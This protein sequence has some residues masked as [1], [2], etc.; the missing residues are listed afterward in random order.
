MGHGNRDCAAIEASPS[1]AWLNTEVLSIKRH[2][3]KT[4]TRAWSLHFAVTVSFSSTYSSGLKSGWMILSSLSIRS[5]S[6][7]WVALF[8][9][10]LETGIA[11]I[12]C[13]NV[14]CSWRMWS[15]ELCIP[16]SDF[17]TVL[18]EIHSSLS[19][20]LSALVM[21]EGD[22]VVRS[23]ASFW[24]GYR[25][26]TKAQ[27]RQIGPENRLFGCAVFASLGHCGIVFI[28]PSS[29]VI[30]LLTW[31]RPAKSTYLV[32]KRIQGYFGEG[33]WYPWTVGLNQAEQSCHLELHLFRREMWRL[34]LH[35]TFW[36][37]VKWVNALLTL[38]TSSS[39]LR[40]W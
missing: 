31:G 32:G 20:M 11:Q 27:P 36:G 35:P 34:V 38:L 6:L 23:K 10:S 7:S 12:P 22:P 17:Q 25:T 37:L 16:S 39:I 14:A 28:L 5:P 3:V 33:R 29:N 24:P 18:V 19:H 1:E 9:R 30:P 13:K 2:K 21:L 4:K 8:V 40:L 26:Q 15:S